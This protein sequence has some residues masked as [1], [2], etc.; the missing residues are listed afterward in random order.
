MG[1]PAAIVTSIYGCKAVRDSAGSK[2]CAE[3]MS[4][5]SQSVFSSRKPAGLVTAGMS[6]DDRTA[7][8]MELRAKEG[9]QRG[10]EGCWD[11]DAVEISA[12]GIR[13]CG[14]WPLR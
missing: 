11:K 5:S 13:L 7:Y 2:I 8:D 3:S 9:P 14:V 4:V 12:A 6:A 1:A 10:A